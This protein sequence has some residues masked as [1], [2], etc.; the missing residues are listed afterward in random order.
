MLNSPATPDWPAG[1]AGHIVMGNL[2]EISR[3][4]L[5]TLS[6]Y[7]HGTETS[8]CCGLGQNERCWSATRAM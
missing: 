7:A 3:D 6:G 8:S 5:G 2:P 1:P 4:W